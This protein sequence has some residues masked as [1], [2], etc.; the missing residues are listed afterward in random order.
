MPEAKRG[1]A[2]YAASTRAA[3]QGLTGEAERSAILAGR[4]DREDRLIAERPSGAIYRWF[5]GRGVTGQEQPRW[6]HAKLRDWSLSGHH[7]GHYHPSQTASAF[8]SVSAFA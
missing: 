1:A 4:K 2:L 7:T 3:G 8:S 5:Q 6:G